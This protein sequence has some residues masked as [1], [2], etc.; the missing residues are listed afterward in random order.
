MIRKIA[1][2]SMLL[3]AGLQLA[4]AQ[5]VLKGKVVDHDGNPIAGAKV[6][7]AKGNEQTTT[8]MNGQFFLEADL[9]VKKVNVYY[10]GLQTAHKKAKA[11][12][13]VKMSGI[14]WWSTKPEK[15]SWFVGPQVAITSRNYI[16]PVFGLTIGRVK[17]WGWYVKGLYSKGSDNDYGT[18]DTWTTNDF[19]PGYWSATGGIIRRCFGQIHLYAGAGYSSMDRGIKHTDGYYDSVIIKG[20]DGITYELGLTLRMKHF[21]INGGGM[22]KES[23]ATHAIANFGLGYI[24]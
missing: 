8:D 13:L 5:N 7:N 19:T 15:Y 20:E 23:G 11:D 6:E 1:C 2:I 17:N 4:S 12:M 9:P 24:F 21:F 22:F 16:K 18:F 14:C 3:V 10:M